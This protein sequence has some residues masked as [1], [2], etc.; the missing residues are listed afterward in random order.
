VLSSIP[1]VEVVGLEQRDQHDGSRSIDIVA[2]YKGQLLAVEV[3]GP[4][5]FTWLGERP[6]GE[7]LARN[8][9]LVA[10]GYRVVSVPVDPGW[11]Q[12]RGQ[13]QQQ[14]FLQGLLDGQPARS[15]STPT[16]MATTTASTAMSA[17]APTRGTGTAVAGG[18]G[19]LARPQRP[20]PTAGPGRPAKRKST[21]TRS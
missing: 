13:Q 2:R 10:R 8:R 17:P 20:Q 4:T 18:P 14:S 9:A 12:Q 11:R 5:H 19:L 1:G 21:Q 16:S 3:D 6:T 7:T 15:T